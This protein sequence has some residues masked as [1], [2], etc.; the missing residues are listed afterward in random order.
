MTGTA[1]LAVTAAAAAAA[2]LWSGRSPARAGI[3]PGVAHPANDDGVLRRR[4]A[5]WAL[6]AGLGGPTWFSGWD[7][8]VVCLAS[9]IAVWWGIGRS[10]PVGVRRARA[11]ARA[12]LPHLVLLLGAALR[13]GAAP[14]PAAGVV[15]RALPGPAADRLATAEAQLA[16]G[17]DPATVWRDLA[18]DPE[19]APLGRCLARAHAT[20]APVAEAITRL[21][22]E[23]AAE[24]RASVQDRARVVGVKAALPLGLCLLPAFLLLGVV[25]VVAALLAGLLV[26]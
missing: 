7:A 23:L 25:P 11:R 8:V 22:R 14:G 6:L 1:W 16:L 2:V 24:H 19:L 4:R 3:R 9:T 5:L 18:A 21:G 20:G 26:G 15:C 12:E 10:E 13:A 17:A